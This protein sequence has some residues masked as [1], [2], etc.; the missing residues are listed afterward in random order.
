MLTNPR[1]NSEL[2][3][4]TTMRISFQFLRCSLWSMAFEFDFGMYVDVV[5][6]SFMLV[7]FTVSSTFAAGTECPLQHVCMHDLSYLAVTGDV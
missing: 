4:V 2:S 6:K 3:I 1:K 7:V 5:I